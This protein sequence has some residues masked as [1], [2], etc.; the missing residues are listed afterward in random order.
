[1]TGVQTCALPISIPAVPGGIGATIQD[2]SGTQPILYD[3]RGNLGPIS[4]FDPGEEERWNAQ[5]PMIPGDF[6]GGIPVGW[7]S[8]GG[9][10]NIQLVQPNVKGQMPEFAT[11]DRSGLGIPAGLTPDKFREKASLLSALSE[12]DPKQRATV[13]VELAKLPYYE[14]QKMMELLFKESQIGLNKERM[15]TEGT[16]RGA[17]GA[18]TEKRRGEKSKANPRVAYLQSMIK[19]GEARLKV[20]PRM[21]KNRPALEQELKGYRDEYNTLTGGKPASP[22][23]KP[24]YP[25]AQ[26][27][28]RDGKWY[29]KKDGKWNLVETR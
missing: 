4:Q 2:T 12:M 15:A 19:D 10:Q 24:P 17:L 6:G 7:T 1:V 22:A 13:E 20:T 8:P 28:P 16:K 26:K 25:G 27:S 9:A 11:G 14:Q 21:D 3:E 18:L 23:E 5:H 29:V